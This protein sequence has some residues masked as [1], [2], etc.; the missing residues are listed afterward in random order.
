MTRRTIEI[1][2]FC[3]ALLLAA[4]AVHAWLDSRDEQQR[5][6][7]TLAAQKQLLD[8]ADSR[9]RTRQSALD[10]T[11]AQIESLKRATLT[12]EQVLRDL[13]KYLP[14][15]QPIT[16]ASATGPDASAPA[17]QGT[18]ASAKAAI[19]RQPPSAFPTAPAAQIPSADLKPLYDYVQD[20]RACQAQL[21]A[22]KQNQADDAAKLAA[23]T[24]ERD[25]AV[26][27]TKGGTFWRRLRRNAAWFGVGAALGAAA[28]YTASKR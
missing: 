28:G 27:A 24:R 9:E 22:A 11:L 10:A 2:G 6:A 19:P 3:A 23:L 16:L 5:L 21:A 18:D 25:A 12:P 1:A 7:S 14:L 20:C 8:A 26:T 4:M 17:Q 13:P 15:P